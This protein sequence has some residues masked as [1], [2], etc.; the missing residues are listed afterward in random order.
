MKQDCRL[1]LTDLGGSTTPS[2]DEFYSEGTFKILLL[3]FLVEIKTD[4][5]NLN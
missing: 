4:N 3:L 2:G 5:N 1:Y